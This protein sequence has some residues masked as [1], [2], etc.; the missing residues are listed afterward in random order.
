MK[1]ICTKCGST[2]VACEA[3]INPNNK[4]FINYTDEA[5]LYGWCNKCNT[6]VILTDKREIK[7]EIEKKFNEFVKKNG[8]EP[9]YAV[10]DIVWKDNNDLESVKIQ[11]S[12]DSNPDEDDDFFFYCNSLNELKSLCDFGSEDFIVTEIDRLEN[13]D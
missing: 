8:K 7:A 9:A 5:F 3:M 6:G 2:D 1:I 11:L 12:A 13:N 10:C 4:K